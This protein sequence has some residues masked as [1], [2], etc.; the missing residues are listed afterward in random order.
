[1]FSRNELGIEQIVS[2]DRWLVNNGLFSESI[3]QNLFGFA[4]LSHP[5]VNHST[6][7]VVVDAENRNVSFEIGLSKGLLRYRLYKWIQNKLKG[8]RSL[9]CMW[10]HVKLLRRN[11][12]IDVEVILRKFVKDYLGNKWNV[13]VDVFKG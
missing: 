13:E 11:I 9:L 5:S 6:V 3:Q 2:T 8:S 1:M 7:K 10:L 12:L 4:C